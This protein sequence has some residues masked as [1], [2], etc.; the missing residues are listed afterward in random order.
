MVFELKNALKSI[1]LSDKEIAVYEALLPLGRATVR[2]LSTRTGIN[3]GTVYD[4]LEELTEKGML[5]SERKGMRRRFLVASPDKLL[6][7]LDNRERQIKE[8]KEKIGE[9]IPQLMS[10]YAKQGGR[11]LVEYF[12]SDE[13]IKHILEDVLETLSESGEKEY[14]LYS[15]NSV[16]NY[17][18]N[19]FPNFTKEKV[20]RGIK[21]RVIAFGEGHDPKNLQMAER[22][23]VQSVAPAYIIVYG[24]KLA[25]LS[26]ADDKV[27][28]GV[29]IK[30]EKIASTQ[31]ILF[32]QLW[33]R[34]V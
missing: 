34:L 21:T 9:V 11:P 7:V 20:K 2:E 22:K 25:L 19:L 26:V 30:D 6:S 4:I 17:L 16:K 27:P 14:V 33:G 13:G 32:E 1:D 18:Y 15:S 10:L 28:F 12:D 31:R 24:P 29:L 8:H 23:T 3:R 5:L